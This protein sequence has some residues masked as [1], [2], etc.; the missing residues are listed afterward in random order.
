VAQQHSPT[1]SNTESPVP[2]LKALRTRR[3][4]ERE[5]FVMIVIV[6]VIYII[7]KLVF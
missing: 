5:T 1:D 4:R 3:R 7:Y 2:D 6:I